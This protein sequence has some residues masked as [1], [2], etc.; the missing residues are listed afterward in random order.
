[1]ARPRSFEPEKALEQAMLTF[2]RLGYDST[3]VSD[4]VGATGVNRHS[5]YALWGDKKGLFLAA[6]DHYLELIQQEFLSVMC[7]PDADIDSIAAFGERFL[8]QLEQPPGRYGCLIASAASEL[9]DNDADI[10]LRVDRHTDRLRQAFGNALSGAAERGQLRDGLP[11]NAV[12]EMFVVFGRGLALEARR[13]ADPSQL[14]LAI[15]ATLDAIRAPGA[16]P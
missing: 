4:L 7:S 5:L 8:A 16:T 10:S 11:I 14:R 1:M 13:G 2:W 12:V 3:A 6:L 9:A 15:S